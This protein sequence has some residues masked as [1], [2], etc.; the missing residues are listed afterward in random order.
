M[1]ARC[2]W[3][4]VRTL[5]S[6]RAGKHRV[7][8]GNSPFS[9][10]LSFQ[11]ATSRMFPARFMTSTWPE[12]ASSVSSEM[13]TLSMLV[14]RRR[15]LGLSIVAR[16]ALRISSRVF[17]VI[18][19]V[20]L[21]SLWPISRTNRYL[22]KSADTS[23]SALTNEEM[24]CKHQVVV[25]EPVQTPPHPIFEKETQLTL[26]NRVQTSQIRLKCRP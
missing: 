8:R 13:R 20:Y 16:V 17:L 6:A 4:S 7:S 15:F 9:V 23:R 10:S 21:S 5:A 24:Y 14:S 12:I 18:A 3:G 26:H 22:F 19:L 1:F 11:A 25:L 2:T